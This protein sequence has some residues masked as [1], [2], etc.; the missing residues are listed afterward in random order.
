MPQLCC[1]LEKGFMEKNGGDYGPAL[2]SLGLPRRGN[3]WKNWREPSKGHQDGWRLEQ[4]VLEGSGIV[5]PGEDLG[6]SFL[7]FTYNPEVSHSWDIPAF[8]AGLGF[9]LENPGKEAI[10][11]FGFHI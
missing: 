8:P 9:L 7:T 11:G 10:I 6:Q 3:P 5:L 4:G 2:P 1:E